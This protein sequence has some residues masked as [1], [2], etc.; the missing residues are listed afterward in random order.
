VRFEVIGSNL[1]I[2]ITKLGGEDLR[3][4]PTD[5]FQVSREIKREIKMS[6]FHAEH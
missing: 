1:F 5:F 4:N 2:L 6:M 3:Y